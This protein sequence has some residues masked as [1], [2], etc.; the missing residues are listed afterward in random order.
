M[1]TNE[2]I[3]SQWDG[4]LYSLRV[5]ANPAQVF[6]LA[7]TETSSFVPDTGSSTFGAITL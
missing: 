2:D 5:G 4:A 6:A 7:D 1:G 3:P